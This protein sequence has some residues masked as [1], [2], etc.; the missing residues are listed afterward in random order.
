MVAWTGWYSTM[1][2]YGTMK[3]YGTMDWYGNMDRVVW[4]HGQGGQRAFG[5]TNHLDFTIIS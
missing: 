2:W 4:Y 1:D 5:A 3:W